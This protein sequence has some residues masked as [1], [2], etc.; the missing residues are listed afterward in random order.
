MAWKQTDN[1]KNITQGNPMWQKSWPQVLEVFVNR[2][3][4]LLD[5]LV[6]EKEGE[7]VCE[8]E[9]LILE[10]VWAKLLW[11]MF[12][13]ESDKYDQV[14]IAGSPQKEYARRTP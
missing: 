9:K 12:Y 8:Q 2:V 13:I 1:Y 3:E 11:D 6:Y 7:S 14:I 5:N 4:A 10:R